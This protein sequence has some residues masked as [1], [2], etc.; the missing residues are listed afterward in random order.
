LGPINSTEETFTHAAFASNNDKI[1]LLAAYDV[2]RRLLVYRIE[3]TWNVPPE[4]KN[5]S[6][7]H[8]DKPVL[9]ISLITV[10]ENC[11]PVDT[12]ST[13]LTNGAETGG[14][15]A[16][17]LTQLNFMP[18]TPEKD[19][20]SL[21]TI[22]AIFCRPPNLVNFDPLQ[23]QDPQHSVI[24][25]WEVQET[26]Q[27]Q[28][29]PSLDQ[30]TS[31]KKRIDSVAD[32]S[33]LLL[34]RQQDFPLA[35]VA[36]AFYP[37]CYNVFLA[38]CYS[39]GTIEMRRRSTLE[40]VLPD[41]NPD[42]IT[43]LLQAGFAFAQ[44]EPSLHVAFSP[45]HCV[46][47]CMQLDGDIKLRSME[48]QHGDLSTDEDNDPR[49]T[50]ALAAV[51]L[52]SASAANQYCSSDDILSIIGPLSPERIHTF[53][54]LMFEGLNVNPD[55]GI[56]EPNNNIPNLG[57]SPGFA[58]TLSALNLLGLRSTSDRSFISKLA[59]L[60]INVK[61]VSQVFSLLQ[62][63]N[64]GKEPLLRPEFVPQSM[65]L[66]RWIL[67]FIAYFLDELFSIGRAVEDMSL[68]KDSL[69]QKMLE[70]N[71]PA[72]LLLL[73]GF[74]RMMMKSYL[75]PLLWVKRSADISAATTPTTPPPSPEIRKLYAPLAA[76][77]DDLPF[78]WRLFDRL[79]ADVHLQVRT[80]YKHAN[81][82]DKQRNLA[83]RDLLLGRIPDVLF[84]VAKCIVTDMLFSSDYPNGCLADNLDMGHLTFFDTKWLGFTES[85]RS[86]AWHAT[87]VVDVCQKMI[88]RGLGA[89]SHPVTGTASTVEVPRK[90]NGMRVC[91]RCGS[92]ME[93]IVQGIEGYSSH[94]VAWSM[95]VSKHCIC[96]SSWMLA[97]EKPRAK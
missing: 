62:R 37:L 68:T 81:L 35:S 26:Q 14:S 39:D 66:V 34:K 30:V 20:A 77:F 1:L 9:H 93:D 19:N 57:R 16:S 2:A 17:Q 60:T 24:V 22:Q 50:A 5:P 65:G 73:S 18:A 54:N 76:A 86:A 95:S 6:A 23:A 11:S 79:I 80:A 51:V 97:E 92:Y 29:H 41:G 90:K 38:F 85:K 89:Q 96:G 13:E 58:K 46:A 12:V 83:E 72:V 91:I 8:I 55:I 74:P 31:K 43:S 61:F 48:Y 78:Q 94:H 36:I 82:S 4:K 67:H 70:L 84:P 53:A 25:R 28:L 49:H 44:T 88:I 87:H 64:I 52:Q 21:P 27:A 59:W 75:P 63:M 47:V 7:G 56:E 15:I 10:E 69:T 33:V 71:K 32:K 3:T 40:L 42:T 45:N